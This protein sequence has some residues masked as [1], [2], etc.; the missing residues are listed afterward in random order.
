[1]RFTTTVEIEAEPAAVWAVME[2]V[3]RWP[4]WTPTMKSVA[5]TS[6]EVVGPESTATIRQPALP[7]AV[8]R[9]TSY[10]AGRS[11]SWE[12]DVRGV[13]MVGDHRVEP[14]PGGRSLVTLG[15]TSSGVLSTIFGPLIN[16]QVRKAVRTEAASLKRH[17]EASVRTATAV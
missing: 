4:D 1:M 10:E 13:H 3:N 8:W 14:L 2:D 16:G 7:P 17:V 15:I 11:F 9:V 6:G 5:L 12:T